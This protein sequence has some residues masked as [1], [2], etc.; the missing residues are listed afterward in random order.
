MKSALFVLT[1]WQV[2]QAI[3]TN[4]AEKMSAGSVMH[5]Q[6]YLTIPGFLDGSH[7]RRSL[8]L[9]QNGDS[10]QKIHD[11][12]VVIM[13]M[14]RTPNR[15]ALRDAASFCKHFDEGK[16]ALSF[17]IGANLNVSFASDTTSRL[18][19]DVSRKCCTIVRDTGM[20]PFRTWGNI[21][22]DEATFWKR[23]DCDNEVGGQDT[24]RCKEVLAPAL[25]QE[26]T[27]ASQCCD[28][29]LD[30]GIRPRGQ[31]GN[32]LEVEANFWRSHH[33]DTLVGGDKHASKCKRM[34]ATDL[35]RLFPQLN[36]VRDPPH[37]MHKKKN[38]TA[39]MAFLR[40]YLLKETMKAFPEAD[41]IINADLDGTI[42]WNDQ[43]RGVLLSALSPGD[44]EKWDGVTFMADFYYDF[45]AARCTKDSWN[46]WGHESKGKSACWD[47]D[48]YPCL[49]ALE[50][51]KTSKMF[52]PVSSAFNGL[53]IYKKGAIGNCQYDGTNF[54]K[55]VIMGTP[56]SRQ[57]CEHVA[58]NKCLNA[59]GKKFMLNSGK[60][61]I[62]YISGWSEDDNN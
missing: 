18:I 24:P 21:S 55:D 29:V 45:W 10:L 14:G 12:F 22:Q 26:D 41:F 9:M 28:L 57:D 53:A 4:S 13:G 8:E 25:L 60:L 1:L 33:C 3:K 20:N 34:D 61:H 43:T 56:G 50:N 35:T 49:S 36:L 31:W 58:F 16:C 11:K 5:F 44:V 17:M 52:L 38:A 23:H 30:K 37:E 15:S 27:I 32:A 51:D 46:C 6:R 54:D 42:S 19:T 47:K 2:A 40:N 7:Q 39:K 62:T 48:Q 59:A